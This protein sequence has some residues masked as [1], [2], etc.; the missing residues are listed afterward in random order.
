MSDR[1]QDLLRQRALSQEQLAWLDREIAATSAADATTTPTPAPAPR[2][3]RAPL[4]Q[5]GYLA[6]QPAAIAEHQAAAA[7][8][9]ATARG[10]NPAVAAAA[11][12]ILEKYRVQPDS[13]KTDVRQGCFLY[14]FGAL[15]VVAVIIAGLYST[16]SS[17]TP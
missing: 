12:A 2:P 6:S 1:L 5:P 8:D 4:P 7:R 10:E 17:R 14:F 13:L 16:L 3:A 11:D 9:P 15:A